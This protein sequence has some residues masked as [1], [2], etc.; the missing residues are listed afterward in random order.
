MLILLSGVT[1]RALVIGAEI[2]I[3]GTY[4]YSIFFFDT[5]FLEYGVNNHNF[6]MICAIAF[7]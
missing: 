4:A 3:F 6:G 7:M 5:L 2:T 1:D